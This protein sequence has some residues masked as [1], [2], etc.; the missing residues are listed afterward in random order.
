MERFC[1]VIV[2]LFILWR[3]YRHDSYG[4]WHLY[5]SFFVQSLEPF[6]A[7]L[8]FM[9][10]ISCCVIR[11]VFKESWAVR[12]CYSRMLSPGQ[13][14]AT[15]QRN[16]SQHCWAQHVACVWP[17][18]CDVLQH[19]G[20]S[21]LKFETGQIW[22][23][24]TQHVAT[25]WP[26]ARNMLRPTMLRYVVLACC[27]RLAG[28]LVPRSSFLVPRSSFLVPRSSFL[29]PRSPILLSVGRR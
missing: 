5:I 15:C 9:K 17:P 20:C 25:G 10:G 27:D 24:N 28:A 26:N 19:V 14:I 11:R 3:A 4:L 16:I 29:V 21:W 7:S 23:N 2:G 13:T 12:P 6:F 1:L 8:V 18:C 22:A